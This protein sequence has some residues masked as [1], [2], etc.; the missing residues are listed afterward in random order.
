MRIIGQLFSWRIGQAQVIAGARVPS[1]NTDG[2][3]T[4]DLDETTNNTILSQ[5]A[6]A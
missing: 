6:A 2:L 4:A 3:Y 1:T 5:V